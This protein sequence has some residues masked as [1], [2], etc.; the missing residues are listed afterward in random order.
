[1]HPISPLEDFVIDLLVIIAA[2][3]VVILLSQRLRLNAIVGFLLTGML[4]GPS[5]LGLVRREEVELLAEIGVVILLFTIGLEFSLSQLRQNWRPFLVGGGLQV[6]LTVAITL[7]VALRFGMPVQRAIFLGFLA[8]LSST[9]I[10]LKT[11]ADRGEL[12]SPQGTILTGIL[13][14]QDFSLAPMIILMPV[15]AGTTTASAGAVLARLAIGVLVV[16]AVFLVARVLMPR[17]MQRIVRTGVREIFLLGALGACLAM[18][19]LTARFGFSMALG[20]FLA[21]L[22]LSESEYSH[23]VSAEV[24]P[25]RHLFNSLFF[26][27]LGMLLDLEHLRPQ[28][29]A[30]FVVG[31]G[32]MISKALVATA[33]VS[34][35]MYPVRI[36]L[37]TG[38]SLAQVGEFSFVLGGVGLSLGLLDAGLYQTFLGASILTMLLTPFVVGLAPR[39]ARQAPS[40]PVPAAWRR[41]QQGHRPPGAFEPRPELRGHVILVGYGLNGRNVARVLRETAVPFVVLELNGHLVQEARS[42]GVP[43]VYGDATRVEILDVC[44]LRR[45]SV[46]VLAISDLAATRQAVRMARSS[47]PDLFI[48]ARTRALNEIDELYHLGADEVLPEEFETSVEIFSRVLE[49]YHVPRNVIDA[50]VRIIRGEGYSVLRGGS[51]VTSGAL[52]R[53]A[54]MLEGTL[55]E[56]YLVTRGSRAD[57]ATLRGLDLRG[58]T[59]ASVIAV[60]RRGAPTTNPSPDLQLEASDTLVLVGGHAALEAAFAYLEGREGAPDRAGETTKGDVDATSV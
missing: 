31:L 16:A 60:V 8:A 27:S 13:L 35:M 39:L 34:Y 17:L 46:L 54:E 24:L 5:G 11:Y 57:G 53:I 59:Q 32:L 6:V 38:L 21:G 19:M 20:A 50:Q 37:V 23:Q 52:E 4:L 47:N 33:V 25:F 3:V 29:P 18:A 48:L 26:I 49:R 40:L 51:L 2:S 15:L 58:R 22:I 56:T 9:A 28:L 10:V 43:V 42:D 1:M 7:A 55:T 45:A 44:G 41:L 14:F 30:V 12:H 36:A